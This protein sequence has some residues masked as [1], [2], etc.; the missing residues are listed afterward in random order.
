MINID[1]KNPQSITPWII[2]TYDRIKIID[3]AIH[4]GKKIALYVYDHADTS[5]FRYRCYNVYQATL[6]SA[7]WQAVYFYVS[8]LTI[9]KKILYKID[10]LIFTRN[11]WIIE[12]DPLCIKARNYGLK[13]IFDVDDLVFD[14]DKL[15]LLTNTL[16]IDLNSNQ[17]YDFWF[18]Y[19]GRIYFTAK[20]ADG[21]F[22]TN[23]FLGE[24]LSKK[25]NKPYQII[26]NSLNKEQLLV[27]H[28]ICDLKK[29]AKKNDEFV[30][31]YFSGTP[32]HINDF[33]LIYK[34]LLNLLDEY[35]SIKLKI[36]GFMQLPDDAKSYLHNGQI[37]IVPLVDFLELQRLIAEVD[38]NIV[39]LV[40]N[41]FTNCKSE[42]K[43][44]EAAVVNT[45]TV[46]SPIYTYTNAIEHNVNGFLCEQ[47]Q[48]F[49]TI[50]SLYLGSVDVQQITQKAY[51][52]AISNYSGEKFL[53]MIEN[54]FDYFAKK[55]DDQ[56]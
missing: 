38:V 40:D 14:L 34:E 11:K 53:T 25:F 48:W 17:H 9:V 13:I 27:S 3:E 10:V 19:I 33:L 35:K 46:S 45:I 7:R 51:T 56:T 49:N 5:T 29:K 16:S 18:S 1:Y 47:G 21:F 52:H 39:P 42:L 44:F 22:T 50:K 37:Q 8:E 36:V 2:S 55:Q 20:R 12:F 41:E 32:S 30:I 6:E 24:V 43:Y 28:Q 26:I 54:C 15:P 23:P 4:K 31:G